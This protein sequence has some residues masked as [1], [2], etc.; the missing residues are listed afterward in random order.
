MTTAAA[1]A[2]PID[3]RVEVVTP[4][5]IAFE[6]RIAGPFRRLPAYLIDKLVQMMLL[7]GCSIVL[8]LVAGTGMRG[9]S[10]GLMLTAW[11]AISWFYGGVFE[12]LWNG[13]TPG[14]RA[15]KLRAISDNGQPLNAQQAVLTICSA[16]STCS[17]WRRRTYSGCWPRPRTIDF[18]GWAIWPVA[19]W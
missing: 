7:A 15:F 9:V 18:S 12:T 19:Q 13:Q 10:F 14:K 4:E 16:P 11:F 5:S 3:T 1:P 8:S 6:Y 2:G 17:R